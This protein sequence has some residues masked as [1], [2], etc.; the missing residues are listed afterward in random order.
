MMFLRKGKSEYFQNLGTLFQ[1][2]SEQL[3]TD[4]NSKQVLQ[5]RISFLIKKVVDH[6]RKNPGTVCIAQREIQCGKL[7]INNWTPTKH[8]VMFIF[9]NLSG[10]HL[11]IQHMNGMAIFV[12]ERDTG[13]FKTALYIEDCLWRMFYLRTTGLDAELDKVGEIEK[14]ENLI[15]LG[16]GCIGTNVHMKSDIAEGMFTY[17][18]ECTNNNVLFN[19][20]PWTAFLAPYDSLYEKVRKE[21]ETPVA[22]HSE[23]IARRT[24]GSP[25]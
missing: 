12:I 11:F 17:E 10:P 21:K 20:R 9:N 14:D 23:R 24:E 16:L 3:G 1:N 22:R 6:E 15:C 8:D 5:Q 18:Y 4:S 2:L 25:Y 7:A 19:R 13:V